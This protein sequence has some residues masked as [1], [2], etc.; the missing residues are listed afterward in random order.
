[1]GSYMLMQLHYDFIRVQVQ[2]ALLSANAMPNEAVNILSIGTAGS[3]QT[4]QTQ[5]R[6]L[7]EVV[8]LV[9]TLFAVYSC[10]F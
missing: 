3:E 10:I 2:K 4:V 6:L 9:S 8:G 1:M 5:I 7:L